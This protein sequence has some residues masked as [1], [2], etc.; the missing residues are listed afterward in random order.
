MEVAADLLE[1]DQLRQLARV[2]GLDLPPAL[3]Q[4]RLDVREPEE[5]VDARLLGEAVDPL[6]V[7]LGDPVL[8]DGESP[9]ERPLAQLH[10][11]RGRAGEVLEEVPEVVFRDDSQIEPHPGVG[12]HLRSAVTARPLLGDKG[13]LAE[14]LD[15]R[16]RVRGRRHQVDVLAGLGPA[17][18]RAGDLDPARRRVLPQRL[19]DLAGDRENVREQPPVG[20]LSCV[21]HRLERRQ[22]VLLHGGTE[23]PELADLALLGS[24]PETLEVLDPELVVEATRGLRPEPRD[25]GHLN[26]RGGE[27]LLQLLGRG[28]AAGLDQ[29][30]DLLRQGLADTRELGEPALLGELLQGDGAVASGPRRLLIGEHPIAVGPVEVVE[31]AQLAEGGGDLGVAHGPNL[32]ASPMGKYAPDVPEPS[33]EA[34]PRVWVILPT[35]NEAEN[36]EPLVEAV[37]E[38]L[39]DSRRVLIVDDSSPDGTGEIADRLATEHDDVAVLHRAVKE[40]LGPA[41]IAGF[42]EALAG[43]AELVIEMDSDFSHDP[44]NLPQLLRAAGEADLVIGSRYVRGGGVTDWGP[45]RRLISRGGSTYARI[46]LGIGVRDLTGGF[47]CL[48]RRVLEGIDLGSIDSLGYAFQ[49]EV[50]YRAIQAGFRVVEVPIVFRDR[51]QGH[52]KMNKAIV[53]EAIWRV[54]AMRLKRRR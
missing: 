36:I 15:Q 47:K 11:V 46:V 16:R 4:L 44:A 41:Y 17:P 14:R 49:V 43:G 26:Q 38:R 27:L 22:H 12:E 19:G 45:M 29:G 48:R 21:R 30:D 13:V 52:S 24:R 37:L 34:D 2:A 51:Q 42:H 50:T 18:R 5:L 20:V 8:G 31:D 35:Y 7:G 53:A 28:D 3:P 39:P 23:A 9:A 32:P 25:P 6:A 1:P 10:V 40:G 33:A 54:P